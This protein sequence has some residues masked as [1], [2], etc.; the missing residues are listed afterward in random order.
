MNRRR[1]PLLVW[2]VAL[3]AVCSCHDWNRSPLAPSLQPAFGARVID[4]QLRIWTG[5]R[6]AGI[7][8]FAVRFEPSRAELVLVSSSGRGEEVEHLTLGG[9]Y[10]AGLEIFQP[11]PK[12]FDWHNQESLRISVYGGSGGWGTSTSLAELIGGSAQHPDDTYWFQDVGWLNPAEVA[13]QDGKKF[14]ATCTPDSAKAGLP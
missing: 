4:G 11:L 6:C 7:T 14:L 13:A 8:R 1:Y 9:P 3:L 10:P 2:L 5:S 12:G